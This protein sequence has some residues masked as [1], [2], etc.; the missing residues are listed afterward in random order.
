MQSKDVVVRLQALDATWEV[1][2]V[3]RK[4]GI[5]VESPLPNADSWGPAG[6][7]FEMRRDP[8]AI[9]PDLGAFTPV[10]VE[11]AGK[12]VWS[13]WISETPSR[14]GADRM[15]SVQ[16]KGGQAHLDDDVYE[17]AYVHT[18]I[19]EWRDMRTFPGAELGADR[20]LAAGQVANDNGVIQLAF[21]KDTDVSSGA[22]VGVILDL[23]PYN[24]AESISFDWEN[25]PGASFAPWVRGLDTPSSAGWTVNDVFW[26]GAATLSGTGSPGSG[27]GDFPAPPRYVAIFLYCTSPTTTT[28]DVWVKLTGIRVF[29][30]V[31]FRFGDASILKASTVVVDALDRA[32][33]LL[34]SD[35]SGIAETLF[36]IPDLVLA[37]PR[38]PREVWAAVNAFHDYLCQVDVRMRPVFKPKPTAPTLEVGAWSALELEDQSANSGDE[39]YNRVIVTGTQPDGSPLRV[40]RVAA[41]IDD[42]ILQAVTTP[43]PDNPRFDV[44]ASSWLNITRDTGTF[45]T[46]P[47]S[48]K[49]TTP[50]FPASGTFTGTFKKGI[51][52]VLS[53]ALKIAGS[54]PEVYLQLGAGDDIGFTTV[55]ATTSFATYT[56]VWVPSADQTAVQFVFNHPDALNDAWID[57]LVLFKATPTLVDRRGFRRTKVLPV[58][59]ALT[60]AA[61]ATIGDLWL[62]AH[63]TTPY[64]GTFKL[65]GDQAVRDPATGAYVPLEDLLL[66]TGELI[67]DTNAIDPDT[68]GVGRDGRIASVSYNPQAEEAIV[69]LDNSRASIEA[70]LARFDLLVGAGR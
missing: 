21:P 20:A 26:T 48:G 13:G 57:N 53:C 43:A 1:G 2:G 51:A 23:G 42:T 22:Y 32:T 16:C 33:I 31:G 19:S 70:L 38:T 5:A 55:M 25:S 66:R 28:D 30:S 36:D 59:A 17:R 7:S 64:K 56:V 12:L 44:D 35:R 49:L 58:Q 24:V 47:A 69:T 8:R 62:A 9:W 63:K 18:K 50:G 15:I 40:E 10:E 68:G 39:I 11:I 60:E 37:E 46:A 6:F 45:A 4:R 3:D 41:Q 65:T 29:T 14:D 34:D 61:A 27:R 52:Y 54:T 67:R